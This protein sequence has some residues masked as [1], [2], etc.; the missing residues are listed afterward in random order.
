[1]I[2]ILF[3]GIGAL[4]N[5]CAQK[6]IE[7]V[8][9]VDNI[10]CIVPGMSSKTVVDSKA[11]YIEFYDKPASSYLS[12]LS[13]IVRSVII[14]TYSK[15][16]DSGM[17]Y[18]KIVIE[19]AGIN[20]PAIQL[21]CSNWALAEWIPGNNSDLM[22][23]L[24]GLGFRKI[25]LPQF[26]KSIWYKDDK[27]FRR[28]QAATVDDFLLIEGRIIGRVIDKE[29]I[30][31]CE[32]ECLVEIKGINVKKSGL[33]Y[34]K[35]IGKID[36]NRLEIH[37]TPSISPTK[38]FPEIK[39]S[40]AGS[41]VVFVDHNAKHIYDLSGDIEGVVAVGDDTMDIIGEIMSQFQI[42]IIGIVDGDKDGLFKNVRFANDSIKIMTESD[43]EFGEKVSAEVFCGEQ[44][45]D[46]SF[47]DIYAAILAI[48]K[49]K[50]ISVIN[51]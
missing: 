24:E 41:G 38:G 12:G 5:S 50:I 7:S 25:S 13:Q 30:L 37:S 35:K 19:R 27:S 20:I 28:L 43:D 10:R 34:L 33:E 16:E 51:L 18:G 3:H 8:K 26:K 2:A 6:V 22:R 49:D 21:E 32:N 42:P 9:K 40:T 15:S 45:S 39:H 29:V 47:R 46:R 36:I 17:A 11:N 14:V 4:N 44:R 31:I 48:G 23:V 1:M